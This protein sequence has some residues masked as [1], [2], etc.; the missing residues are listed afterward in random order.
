MRLIAL[1]VV[2]IVPTFFAAIALADAPLRLNEIR[3]EQP[4][5]DFDEYIELAGLAGEFEFLK[6][7]VQVV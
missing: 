5:A 6:R 2:G 1:S 3:L 7:V 4:G